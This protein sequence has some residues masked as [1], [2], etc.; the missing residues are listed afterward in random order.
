MSQ[1]ST[2]SAGPVPVKAQSNIYTVLLAIA[3]LALVVVII[4]GLY[5]LLRPMPDGYDLEFGQLFD[6]QKLPKPAQTPA[7]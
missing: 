5:G 3:I 4:F 7:K 2:D 6:P 1:F